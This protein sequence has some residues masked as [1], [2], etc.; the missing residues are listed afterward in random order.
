[1]PRAHQDLTVHCISH[2]LLLAYIRHIRLQAV[3]GRGCPD[4]LTAATMAWSRSSMQRRCCA[5][6]ALLAI[7]AA[8][9]AIHA[10]VVSP[11]VPPIMLI[12]RV[13]SAMSLNWMPARCFRDRHDWTSACMPCVH[14]S[15]MCVPNAATVS[16]DDYIGIRVES[17]FRLLTLAEHP[18]Q[19]RPRQRRRDIFSSLPLRHLRRRLHHRAQ[20]HHRSCRGCEVLLGTRSVIW[21]DSQDP[22]FPQVRCW[23]TC[24]LDLE[25]DAQADRINMQGIE[26]HCPAIVSALVGASCRC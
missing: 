25:D 4:Q 1:M 24:H 22:C 7:A 17:W 6:L 11:H 23:A 15:I 20:Q 26:C 16:M 10:S 3:R 9:P 12:T 21:Q 8:M 2:A 13:F 14:S 18:R 19:E 5:A